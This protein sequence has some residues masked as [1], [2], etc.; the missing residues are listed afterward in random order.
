MPSI[1]VVMAVY[2]REKYVARAI[3]SILTQT[4]NNFEFILVDDGSTDN[5]ASIIKQYANKDKRIKYIKQENNGQAHARNTG[6]SNSECEYIAAMDDDDISVP[7]RLEKQLKFMENNPELDACT[8]MQEFINVDGRNLGY[9]RPMSDLLPRDTTMLKY[10]F[11]APFILGPTTMIKK[12]AFDACSGFRVS[13]NVIEDMDFTLR[14]QERFSA[15]IIG[16][17]LYKYVTPNK[18]FGYNVTT[19]DP[20]HYIKSYISSY[21]CAWFR[22]NVNSDPVEE[23]KSLDEIMTLIP[24]LPEITRDSIYNDWTG[25]LCNNI[26]RSIKEGKYISDEE[27]ISLIKVI[28]HIAPKKFTSRLTYKLKKAKTKKLI[29]KGKLIQVFNTSRIKP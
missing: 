16:E 5:S 10:A 7:E 17:Y 2:N 12:E 26:I 14:F 1:S 8:T 24:K 4:Y 21:L 9:Q 15:A 19:K 23:N 25:Q 6:I 20:V 18:K 29:K 11:P 22:R 27:L 13:P 3:E 28:Q